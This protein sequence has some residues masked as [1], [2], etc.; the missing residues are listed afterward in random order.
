MPATAHKVEV[1]LPFCD[2]H[3]DQIIPMFDDLPSQA[4]EMAEGQMKTVLDVNP[5]D[6][7]TKVHCPVLAIFCE[8]DTSVPE[9]RVPHS[10]RNTCKKP[11]MK[12]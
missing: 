4:W 5:A 11:V 1:N 2:G 6:F 7:L 9:R 3:L 8:D 10:T 12:I